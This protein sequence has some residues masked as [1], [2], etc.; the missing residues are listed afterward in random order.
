MLAGKRLTGAAHRKSERPPVRFSV[1][2]GNEDK[3]EKQI[4]NKEGADNAKL[5][6][7]GHCMCL[8]GRCTGD[9]TG[10]RSYRRDERFCLS[11]KI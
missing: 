7:V 4:W 5:S 3:D 6:P 2:S 9:R 10:Q 11:G 1:P 8:P